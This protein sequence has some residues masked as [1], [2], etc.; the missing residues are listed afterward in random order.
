M[1]NIQA[2]IIWQRLFF[3]KL[4]TDF[5]Q[6]ELIKESISSATISEL[7]RSDV[8]FVLTSKDTFMF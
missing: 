7:S 8:Y 4:L 5:R 2:T 6:S 3:S 1:Y